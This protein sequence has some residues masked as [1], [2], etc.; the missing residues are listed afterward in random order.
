MRPIL[1]TCSISTT[2]YDVVRP[3]TMPYDVVRS[4][5]NRTRAK[6]RS[7]SHYARCR[8]TVRRRTCI[9]AHAQSRTQ[10]VDVKCVVP[11]APEHSQTALLTSKSIRGSCH[12]PAEVLVRIWHIQPS[13][14]DDAARREPRSVDVELIST[15]RKFA[16]R[17][18]IT[19]R[20]QNDIANIILSHFICINLH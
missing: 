19:T 9:P 10:L 1:C 20:S 8:T 7:H 11:P 17:V 15:T 12:C 13:H 4:R 5:S 2:T 16:K 18:K 3:R 6:Y 14:L